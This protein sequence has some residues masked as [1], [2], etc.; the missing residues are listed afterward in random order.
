[1]P[2]IT[3]LLI[4]K[5]QLCDALLCDALLFISNGKLLMYYVFVLQVMLECDVGGSGSQISDVL[6]ANQAPS[7]SGDSSNITGLEKTLCLQAEKESDPQVFLSHLT[8]LCKKYFN[9][10]I[11]K[12]LKNL[13]A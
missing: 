13:M 11:N 6:S 7:V 10:N 3:K 9:Y 4:K 12:I 1:M 8:A 5:R 2:Q